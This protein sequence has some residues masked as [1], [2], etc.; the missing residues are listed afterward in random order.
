MKLF[1]TS[2]LQVFLVSINTIFLTKGFVIG[3]IITSFAINWVWMHNLKR[4]VTCD[5][6]DKLL[7]SAGATTGSISG[8]YFSKLIFLIL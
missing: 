4:T 3:I 8:Y 2:F 5:T 6:R 7:Y 1:L